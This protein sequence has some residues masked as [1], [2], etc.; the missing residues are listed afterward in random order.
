MA[1][2]WAA[3]ERGYVVSHWVSQ[4]SWKAGGRGVLRGEK[5]RYG[6]LRFRSVATT[7]FWRAEVRLQVLEAVLNQW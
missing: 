7:T 4:G 2:T 6:D 5:A 1:A 3:G